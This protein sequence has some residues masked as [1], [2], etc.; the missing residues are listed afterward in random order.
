MAAMR[1]IESNEGLPQDMRDLAK[2]VTSLEAKR[3][4]IYAL[5]EANLISD[6]KARALE[7]KLQKRVK[8]D[9]KTLTDILSAEVGAILLFVAG[10]FLLGLSFG[11]PSVLGYAVF[12]N[13]VSNVANTSLFGLAIFV[14]GAVSF[15]YLRRRR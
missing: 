11:K 1:T 12:N 2:D 9:T 13:N 10:A 15:F 5:R 14:I 8:R 3:E 7:G 4:A 6:Y